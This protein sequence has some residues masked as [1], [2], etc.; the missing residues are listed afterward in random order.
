MG[1]MSLMPVNT[2][3]SPLR[4]LFASASRFEGNRARYVSGPMAAAFAAARS[5]FCF[6]FGKRTIPNAHAAKVGGDVVSWV[7]PWIVDG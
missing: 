2:W 7:S 1:T 6:A 5:N 4:A 3:R